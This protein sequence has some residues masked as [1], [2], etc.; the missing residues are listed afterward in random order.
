MTSSA[1]CASPAVE[2]REKMPRGLRQWV[3]SGQRAVGTLSLRV[4]TLLL[5]LSTEYYSVLLLLPPIL[6]GTVVRSALTTTCLARKERLCSRPRLRLRTLSNLLSHPT[7][8]IHPNPSRDS[9]GNGH[10]RNTSTW[11]TAKS[12]PTPA[13]LTRCILQSFLLTW[14]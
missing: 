5:L 9:R 8:T 14:M 10:K 4:K 11:T 13:P 6:L 3:G 7:A 2:R 1:E 12:A